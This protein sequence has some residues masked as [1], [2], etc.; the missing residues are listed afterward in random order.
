M[1]Q[2]KVR[3][4]IPTK[5]RTIDTF[6]LFKMKIKNWIPTNCPCRLRKRFIPQ[7]GYL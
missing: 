6:P 1:S 2:S 4:M 5:L 3:D 7:L